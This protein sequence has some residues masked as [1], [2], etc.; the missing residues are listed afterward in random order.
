MVLCALHMGIAHALSSSDL[1]SDAQRAV[2][3]RRALSVIVD[4]FLD[5]PTVNIVFPANL[6]VKYH[7]WKYILLCGF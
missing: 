5:N 2:R 3:G 1:L 4:K 7:S 6:P